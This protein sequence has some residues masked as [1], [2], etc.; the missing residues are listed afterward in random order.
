M[1]LHIIATPLAL[2]LLFACGADDDGDDEHVDEFPQ[3]MS[4]EYIA[5]DPANHANQ[6]LRVQAYN[7]MLAVMKEAETDPTTAA[8]KFAEA[9]T[10]Y[11][12]TASLRSKVM[13]R[14]DPHD[15]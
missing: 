4:A 2:S 11:E 14:V 1:K 6:N 9:R 10:L 15:G 13:G 7:D 3:C 12:E 5:F 8:A